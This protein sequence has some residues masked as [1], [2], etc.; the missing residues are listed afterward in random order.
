M[1]AAKPLTSSQREMQLELKQQLAVWVWPGMA[2]LGLLL[3]V[4]AE[5]LSWPWRTHVLALIL[6]FLSLLVWSLLRYSYYLAIWV[7]V[8]GSLAV[9][10][11]TLLWLPTGATLCLL[12]LPVAIASLLLSTWAG[13]GV[14]A[15]SSLLAARAISWLPSDGSVSLMPILVAIWGGA[16]LV[17]LASHS[18]ARSIDSL[19]TSYVRMQQLL[20]AARDQR[21]DLKQTQEDLIHANSE[22]ARVSER[23][24]LMYQVAEDARRAKEEFVA[25]VSHELRTPLNM[26][27]GFSEMISE[28]VDAYGIEL[29]AALLADVS[30]IV[31]NAR[32]LASLVDDVLDLSQV[33]AGQMALTREW[34]SLPEIVE[35]ALVAVRPLFEAKGLDLELDLPGEIPLLFC[36][37]TRIRQVILNLLSNAARFT[38]RGGVHLRVK[39]EGD[40]VI[41]GV[42][43]SGPGIPP[44]HQEH[45]FSP[46]HQVD[47]SSRRRY[48]GTGLGLSI[49][50]RFVE[51]HG[52]KMWLESQVGV[53]S[54]FYFSLPV[55]EPLARPSDSAVR[56]LSA[57]H[58]ENP[59][60]R[61]SKVP[62]TEPLPRFVILEPANVLERLLNRYLE[63]AEILSVRTLEQAIEELNRVPAQAFIINDASLV[64]GGHNLAPKMANIPFGTPVLACWVPGEVEAAAKLGVVRYLLKPVTREALHTA[65]AKVGETVR[66]I[67]LVD[68]DPEVLQ[69]FGRM[70]NSTSRRYRVLRAPNGQ[71]ALTLLRERQPDVMLLDLVM[72]GMDG[73]EV[74]RQKAL[75]PQI[76]AIPVI[77]I[78]AVDP[79]RDSI[80]GNGLTLGRSGGLGFH[81]LLA[82]LRL[83]SEVTTPPKARGG[84]EALRNH[85][86]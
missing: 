28:S 83:W 16:L 67:L 33:E 72:P 22:L 20:D 75:D 78:S 8:L 48:G 66:T 32:H 54:V 42:A 81:D 59:R 45:I 30:I 57:Y 27:S 34:M 47:A 39:R 73:Y 18:A 85:G 35:E 29:P 37:R 68:D 63:G 41:I 69:L 13:L 86:A 14:A 10:C 84:Q 79:A 3:T 82:C 4:A 36:D 1:S 70:L 6:V 53:G 25:N 5:A 51:M 65:L 77:C 61:P 19:W 26:I 71:R 80:I 24:S 7:L 12:V 9:A 74:L 50:K 58:Q 49:S 21:L 2:G 55:Q 44:E 56:W 43:D 46:F 23:L 17:C 62:L 60:I 40:S 31:R 52:G 64:S 15:A 76:R 38:S 11:L